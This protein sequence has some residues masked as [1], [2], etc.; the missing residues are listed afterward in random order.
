MFHVLFA[1]VVFMLWRRIGYRASKQRTPSPVVT[2]PPT[3]SPRVGGSVDCTAS[4]RGLFLGILTVVGVIISM[5]VYFVLIDKTSHRQ[6]ALLVISATE[7]TV[8]VA[9]LLATTIAACRVRNMCFVRKL[10]KTRKLEVALLLISFCGLLMYCVF[11]ILAGSVSALTSLASGLLVVTH[12]LVVLQSCVQTVFIL[13]TLHRSARTLFQAQKKPGRE[14]VTFVLVCNV[15]LWGV[16][17][18]E[19][20]RARPGALGVTQYGAVPWSVITRLTLPLASFY[21]F[22]STVCL[23]AIW[24][25]VY[26]KSI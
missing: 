17:V 1:G 12:S 24:A 19:E 13:C 5:I 4:N 8:C 6:M 9:A 10:D 14:Y 21:R 20:L 11:N 26:K 3:S 2:T 22:H 15:A 18:F 25:N 7:A 16:Y 23:A